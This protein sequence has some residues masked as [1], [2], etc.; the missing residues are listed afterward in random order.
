MPEKMVSISDTLAGNPLIFGLILCCMFLLIIAR[1]RQNGKFMFLILSFYR[2]KGIIQPFKEER[3][4]L[5]A[6][7]VLLMTNF[8]VM[9]GLFGYYSIQILGFPEKPFYQSIGFI[10]ITIFVACCYSVKLTLIRFA[11]FILGVDKGNSEY[12]YTIVLFCQNLGLL[13]FPLIVTITYIDMDYKPTLI[14]VAM[15][16]VGLLYLFRL[17]KA[18]LISIRESIPFLYLFLYLCAFEFSPL[19]VAIKIVTG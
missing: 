19:V 14:L 1:V 11:K 16:V 5:S 10:E 15:V 6:A 18:I 12:S 9:I 7:S 2:G 3:L 13:L 4:M 8:L 17:F